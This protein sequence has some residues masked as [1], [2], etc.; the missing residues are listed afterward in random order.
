MSPATHTLIWLFPVA[1]M[2]H[3]FE[4]LL[5]WEL[6]L[7]QHGAEIKRRV[8]AF[9]ARRIGSIV[10]KSTAQAAASIGLI[11][12]L[13]ALS[14]FLAT[15]AHAY[16]FF[17]VASALFFVHGFVH[18]AQTIAFRGYVP[19]VITSVG[20]VIPYGLLLFSRLTGEGL[21]TW[22]GLALSL[23]LGA[24][25]MAPFILAMHAA[26]DFL[27]TRAARLLLHGPAPT[28]ATAKTRQSQP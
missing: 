23:L 27:L 26:G 28:R 7:N 3:D 25:L 11:F 4:E 17:L 21:V 24:I 8:P 16:G 20:I 18:V 15:E 19:A 5:F 1:F 6:W 2:L 9:L 13:T 22:T 12:G 14:A 10:D